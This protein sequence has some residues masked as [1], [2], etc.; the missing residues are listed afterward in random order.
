MTGKGTW[1][2]A[3]IN[4]NKRDE[5]CNAQMQDQDTGIQNTNTGA[6]MHGNQ[7]HNGY[8]NTGMG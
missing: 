2:S 5:K 7:K 1:R 6:T 3:H 4:E 8:A